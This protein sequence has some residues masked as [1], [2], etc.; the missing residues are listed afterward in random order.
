MRALGLSPYTMKK[1][2]RWPAKI[3][4]GGCKRTGSVTSAPVRSRG[5]VPPPPRHSFVSRKN[6]LGR[7]KN[8]EKP[9]LLRTE[10]KGRLE[11]FEPAG[12]S[13]ARSIPD[14]LKARARFRLAL[15][16][17][18][19]KEIKKPRS[20]S[21]PRLKVGAT[22]F[23][24]ATTPTPRECATGLRYA[25]MNRLGIIRRLKIKTFFALPW[26]LPQA[27][28]G[29]KDSAWP[30][31]RGKSLSP[32][33]LTRYRAALRPEIAVWG[34]FDGKC[35]RRLRIQNSTG[36]QESSRVPANIS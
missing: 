21:G 12:D 30:R 24:P 29:V 6:G 20:F 1:D 8:K 26:G 17:T 35:F 3:N 9:R 5:R 16:P 32:F 25:P 33:S 11:G 27:R 14:G 28:L 34:L 19:V 4:V 7:V 2:R 23:E 15:Q 22:G 31:P 18:S 36:F 13:P 10:V